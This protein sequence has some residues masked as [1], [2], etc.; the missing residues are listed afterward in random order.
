MKEFLDSVG[1]IVIRNIHVK[2][3]ALATLVFVVVVLSWKAKNGSKFEIASALH[4]AAGSLLIYAGLLTLAVLVLVKDSGCVGIPDE[5][6]G[7]IGLF[8]SICCIGLG[9]KEVAE[10]CKG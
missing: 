2:L 8:A 6:Q 10:G 9:G 1:Q 7:L 3:W 5:T 4:I